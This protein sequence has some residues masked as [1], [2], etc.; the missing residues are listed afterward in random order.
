MKAEL[1]YC[2]DT[3]VKPVNE[4]KVAGATP[5]YTGT[6]GTRWVEINDGRTS[7]E[8]FSLDEEG[9]EF[10]GSEVLGRSLVSKGIGGCRR[11]EVA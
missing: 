7:Q 1:T 10:E 3:G 2:I 4:T 5:E 9:F 6:F 8:Q 11:G